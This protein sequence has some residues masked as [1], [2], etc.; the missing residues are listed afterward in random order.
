MWGVT[1]PEDLISSNRLTH[2]ELRIVIACR[3]L[4]IKGKRTITA[5]Q[6]AEKTSI[7]YDGTRQHLAN[8]CDKGF[9]KKRKS[10]GIYYE[11]NP[12][13]FDNLRYY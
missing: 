4:E 1:I 12:V 2:G 7:S 10:F 5:K 8:L 6:L 11:T 9:L 13:F 3:L